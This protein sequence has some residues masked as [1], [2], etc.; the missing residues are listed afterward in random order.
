[1]QGLAL[2]GRGDHKE[3]E[4]AAHFSTAAM[5]VRGSYLLLIFLPFLLL[6]PMLL[7]LA[8]ALQPRAGATASGGFGGVFDLA[9]HV[10]F[11]SA[12]ELHYIKQ[13]HAAVS[14]SSSLLERS[15][16]LA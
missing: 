11:C 14:P 4:D 2:Y 6:G 1:M 13:K 8:Q 16:S 12:R 5:T 15:G 9:P 7:L 10:L 3:D